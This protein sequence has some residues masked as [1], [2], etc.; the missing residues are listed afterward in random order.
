LAERF[1]W[2]TF[3]DQYLELVKGRLYAGDAAGRASARATLTLTF[4]AI[5]KLLAPVLPHVTAELHARLFPGHGSLHTAAWPEPD[6]ALRDGSAEAA[7]EAMVAI[8]GAAR[9]H[10]TAQG[11]SLGAPL[12]G[13]TLVC[14]DPQLRA[15]LE[16]AA[17]DLVAVTRATHIAWAD[18]PTPGAVELASGLWAMLEG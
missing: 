8:M 12:V 3:C 1:F 11:R 10:K 13:L 7:G 18:A 14:A 6:P 9:R 17:P 4:E 2:G 15:S 16:Q 5:L